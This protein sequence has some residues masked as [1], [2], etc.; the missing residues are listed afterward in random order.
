M[1]K[2]K[3]SLPE[4]AVI[5]YVLQIAEALKYLNSK[6]KLWLL[7]IDIVHRDIKPSN[8]LIHEGEVRLADF[9]F[10]VH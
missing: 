4:N 5:T 3:G 6:S 8:I 10:A 9:G 1:L 2:Q 7:I